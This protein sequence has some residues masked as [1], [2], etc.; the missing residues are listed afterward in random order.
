VRHVKY[1]NGEANATAS[2]VSEAK[3]VLQYVTNLRAKQMNV[4]H[5]AIGRRKA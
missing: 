5:V 3:A 1:Y 2:D 4:R